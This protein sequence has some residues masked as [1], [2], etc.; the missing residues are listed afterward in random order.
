MKTIGNKAMAG[1][2]A[3]LA[4]TFAYNAKC[5]D[6]A[7]TQQN[8]N[9]S[10]VGRS[11]RS[12]L[13]GSEGTPMK[14]NRASGLIGMD[15]KNQNGEH[16]GHIT[17]VVFDLQSDRV[18]Y[19][20][21]TTSPKVT[22]GIDEKLLAVPLSAFTIGSD[23][24]HLILNAEKSKVDAATGFTK[25]SWPDVTNPN[26][27]TQQFW[28]SPNGEPANNPNNGL[29]RYSP[30]NNPPPANQNENSGTRPG[31]GNNPPRSNP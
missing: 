11:D 18:S 20:V 14:Y 26:W 9:D 23:Q 29:N 17:D 5:D 21:M 19:V 1:V 6:P 28:Q 4:L 24:K 16:L 13:R 3:L 2:V 27:G 25:N 10:A 8:P 22:L 31:T 12:H 15:V 7:T 30:N